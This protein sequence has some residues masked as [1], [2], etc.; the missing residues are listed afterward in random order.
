MDEKLVAELYERI[1]SDLGM[2]IDHELTFE[3]IETSRVTERAVGADQVHI[4]F[5]MAF[6]YAGEERHGCLLVPLPEAIA[7][8]GYL[9][10]VPDEEVE[11][12]R[13]EAELEPM[14]KDAMIEVANFVGGAADLLIREMHPENHSARSAGC[15]G[16]RAGVRPAFPYTDGEELILGRARARLHEFPE[17]DALIMIPPP[18]A[19]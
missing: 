19:E 17:F 1:G 5:K 7:I 9:M 12:S 6:D 2:I 3:K 8:A 10:M 4:S 15:Q 18:V 13:G 11:A 16:V 14:T